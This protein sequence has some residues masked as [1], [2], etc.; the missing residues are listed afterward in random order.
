MSTM[1][2]PLFGGDN[3]SPNAAAVSWNR[4]NA[5]YPSSWSSSS[6]AI[7][8]TP[9]GGAMT[10]SNFYMATDVAPGSGF[11]YTF[12][13]M[14]NGVATALQVL[15]S[16]LAT[17]ATDST[18]SVSYAAGDTISIQC[19]PSG[20]PATLN[21]QSWNFRVTTSDLTA[22]I[23]SS[24]IGASNSVTN[25]MGLTAG[26]IS[27]AGWS[28]T[29]ADSQIIIP[30]SGTLSNMYAKINANPG[31]SKSFQFTLM[32]NGAATSLDFT[33]SGAASTSGNDTT[34]VVSVSAGD[35]LTIRSIP[36]GTPAT[37][38]NMSFGMVFTPTTPGETFVGFGSALLPSVSVTNYEQI[39]GIGNASWSTTES[40]RLLTPGP[41]TFT[42]LYVKLGTAPGTGNSRT[43]ALRKAG[44][45]TALAVTIADTNTSGNSSATI[46]YSQGDTISYI[47]S[48]TATP[49]AAT[50]GVHAGL[51][52]YTAPTINAFTPIVMIY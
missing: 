5:S 27:A 52:I 21:V 2:S 6:E 15:I 19:T 10:L 12:T 35:T 51:L 1:I 3:S 31:A 40:A 7:R 18:N 14:K 22:P 37:Q 34:H 38:T 20:T 9:V 46:N 16:D 44:S 32:K 39:L 29:E 17:S 24:T 41:Y 30:T 26:H 45:T 25:Y 13:I 4:I 42:K 47:S 28:A 43:F 33:I 49:A 50:G 23:L 48:I 36:T 11:S 8:A